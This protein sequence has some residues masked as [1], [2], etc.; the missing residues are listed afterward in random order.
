MNQKAAFILE[1]RQFRKVEVNVPQ[2]QVYYQVFEENA[3]VVVLLSINEGN[4]FTKEQYEHI[5]R[6]IQESFRKRGLINV[7]MLTVASTKESE[8]AKKVC[9]EQNTWIIDESRSVLLL[10]EHSA[11]DFCGLRQPF[12]QIC[13]E[14]CYSQETESS[15]KEEVPYYQNYHERAQKQEGRNR[16]ASKKQIQNRY[17]VSIVNA[18]LVGIN[19]VVFLIMD[20]FQLSDKMLDQG[21]LYWPMII[22]EHQYYRLITCM[23]L[24]G[25]I[26]HLLNNML[27]LFFIGDKVEKIIGK[28]KYLILYFGAGIIAGVCSMRYNMDRM[29]ITRSIGA[30]GAIFGVVGAI[31]YI[32]IIN[33]G[34]LKDISS[35]QILLFVMLS[36]YGGFTSQGVDNIAHVGGLLAGGILTAI[37]YKRSVR[38]R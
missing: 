25:G 16:E 35:R 5:L 24:H 28:T 31:A 38:M 22:Y 18:C 30:S 21:A 7:S 34:R 14:G 32:V 37:L 12:E 17:S 19:I 26:D 33:R 29:L 23:F 3:H 13:R 8:V 36:L 1:A 11:S 2:I 6:Q 27:V 15:G 20:L 9:G 10:Y 4:E